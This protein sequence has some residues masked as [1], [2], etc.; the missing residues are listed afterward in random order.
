MSKKPVVAVVLISSQDA[1]TATVSFSATLELSIKRIVP[2]R[3]QT[4]LKQV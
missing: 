1:A 3:L 4:N 2:A